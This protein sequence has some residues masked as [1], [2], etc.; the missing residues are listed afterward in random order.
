MKRFL[1]NAPPGRGG[2]VRLYRE[3]YHYLVRVRRLREDAAFPAALPDGRETTVKVLS[4]ADGILIGEC[5]GFERASGSGGDGTP[6]VYLFQALPKGS[7]MDLIVR[8]AAETGVAGIIPFESEYS[9]VKVKRLP[10]DRVKR[11]ERIIKEARQQSGSATTTELRAPCSREEALAYW[12]TLK[13]AHP[14]PVGIL[15][16]QEPVEA[17]AAPPLDERSFH[18]YLEGSLGAAA[19]AVGPE[20]GFSPAEAALFTAAGF[21]PLVTGDTILRTETAALYGAAAVR[22]ILSERRTWTTKR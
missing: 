17:E 10:K 20:G 12:E 9:V 7:R 11:W 8:Q 5:E 6:P 3:D 19:V 1:L 2:I 15:L 16:H 22:V 13:A 4:T 21:R 14:E 18:R